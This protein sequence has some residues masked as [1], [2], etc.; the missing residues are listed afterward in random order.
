MIVSRHIKAVPFPEFIV[1]FQQS[2]Q[3]I[4]LV[5]FQLGFPRS[6]FFNSHEVKV[7]V[8][9]AH[10]G[11]LQRWGRHCGKRQREV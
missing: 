3:H 6:W 1:V 8:I 9:L 11:P 5:Q 4:F 7:V 2:K 10:P